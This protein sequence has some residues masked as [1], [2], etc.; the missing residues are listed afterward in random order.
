MTVYHLAVGEYHLISYDSILHHLHITDAGTTTPAVVV[1]LDTDLLNQLDMLVDPLRVLQLPTDVMGRAQIIAH[2][3]EFLLEDND[4]VLITPYLQHGSIDYL[5]LTET[6][7]LVELSLL[8]EAV[9]LLRAYLHR[10]RPEML[11]G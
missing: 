7:V 6:P 8:T 4:H 1:V 3:A 10:Y 9:H 11:A 5:Q 2:D